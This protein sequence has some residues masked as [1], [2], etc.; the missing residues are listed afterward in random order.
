MKIIYTRGDATVPQV[1]DRVPSPAIIAHICNNV[2]AWGKGFV[3]A[4]SKRWTEPEREY[5]QWFAQRESN[6]FGLGQIK[7]VP[8]EEDIAVA[9]MVAQHSLRP[10]DGCPPIRYEALEQ[11]LEALAAHAWKMG[12]DWHGRETPASVHMPRIGCGLSGGQWEA[13]EPL[14]KYTLIRAGVPVKVYDF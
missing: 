9:N 8:V 11:C 2:S 1:D 7:I 6:D 3:L 10:K 13:I 14:I 5:R 12:T 4:I